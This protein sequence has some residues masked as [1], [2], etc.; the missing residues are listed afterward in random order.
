MWIWIFSLKKSNWRTWCPEWRVWW[1]RWWGKEVLRKL[2]SW[3]RADRSWYL[4]FEKEQWHFVRFSLHSKQRELRHWKGRPSFGDNQVQTRKPIPREII[5]LH[6]RFYREVQRVRWRWNLWGWSMLGWWSFS[7]TV[8]CY[9][10]GFIWLSCFESVEFK[11]YILNSNFKFPFNNID[12]RLK[13]SFL[14]KKSR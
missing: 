8:R 2:R 12:F 10:S 9:Y 3:L 13:I 6:H 11:I 1:G 4:T 7:P 14:L 5:M